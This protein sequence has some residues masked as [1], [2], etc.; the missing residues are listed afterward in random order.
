MGA[1]IDMTG[2]KHNSL[3]VLGRSEKRYEKNG[4]VLWECLCDCG[5]HAVVEGYGLRNGHTK[6]CGACGIRAGARFGLLEVL[7]QS[8]V[9]KDGDS[10]YPWRCLC[11]CGKG[12]VVEVAANNLRSG[13]TTSCGCQQKKRSSEVYKK[14]HEEYTV[15]GTNVRRLEST[16]L[17]KNNKSGYKGVCWNKQRN[18]WSA[19]IGFK[20]KRYRLGFY[21]RV[22]D[23][24]RAR[25]EAEGRIYGEFLEWFYE[26]YP[27]RRKDEKNEESNK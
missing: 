25:K 24:A 11:H 8:K 19:Y 23:A 13:N 22:E 15:E 20:K 27:E 21:S 2:Q 14:Y 6:T 4:Q 12:N 1:F 18:N 17:Q 10:H 7:E 3:L 9:K 26:T 16:V 5:N